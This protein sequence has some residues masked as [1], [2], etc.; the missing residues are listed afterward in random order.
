MGMFFSETIEGL[1]TM[2]TAIEK[3]SVMAPRQDLRLDKVSS[4]T[5]PLITDSSSTEAV[6]IE[7]GLPEVVVEGGVS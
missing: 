5:V 2:Q 6:S 1:G 7:E 4:S 3:I